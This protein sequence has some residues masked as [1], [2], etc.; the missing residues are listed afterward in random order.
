M[1]K[2]RI[3]HLLPLLALALFVWAC[4]RDDDAPGNGEV[5]YGIQYFSCDINGI[6]FTPTGTHYCSRFKFD[7]YPQAYLGIPDGYCVIGGTDCDTWNS[8]ALRINGLKD[9]TGYLDFIRPTFADSC[10]PYY[11]LRNTDNVESIMY[12][13]LLDGHLNIEHFIPRADNNSPFGSI[14]GTF[15]FTVTDESGLDTMR[16]TNGRFR[17]DVPHI[18]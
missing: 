15:Q 18:F 5:D 16:I 9:T 6:P 12:E 11:R 4:E 10:F 14:K 1:M 2:F 7:Y 8:M 3:K 13:K 17:Y